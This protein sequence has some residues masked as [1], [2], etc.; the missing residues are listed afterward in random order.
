MKITFDIPDDILHRAEAIAARRGI[1]LGQLVAEAVEEKVE[2]LR[3]EPRWMAGF[4]ALAD[5]GEE[6]RRIEA[7]IRNE[8][9]VLEP[10]D[11]A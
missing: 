5:L 2:A 6:S 10:E 11:R 4:G 1:P 3:R 9:G 7:K 8:F